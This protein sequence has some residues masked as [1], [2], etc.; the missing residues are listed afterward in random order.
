VGRVPDAVAN[1]VRE[2]PNDPPD[3]PDLLA[4]I[5]PRT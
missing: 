3:Q 1:A 5:A 4:S 2:R